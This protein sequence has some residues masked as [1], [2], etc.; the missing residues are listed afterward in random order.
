MNNLPIIFHETLTRQFGEIIREVEELIDK[1]RI[2]MTYENIYKVLADNSEKARNYSKVFTYD[3]YFQKNGEM[4]TLNKT[5]FIIQKELFIKT[6]EEVKTSEAII[7]TLDDDLD[8]SHQPYQDIYHFED[9]S[10]DEGLHLFKTPIAISNYCGIWHEFYNFKKAHKVTEDVCTSYF[11]L[12]ALCNVPEGVTNVKF[13]FNQETSGTRNSSLVKATPFELISLY[14][15]KNYI[16]NVISSINYNIDTDRDACSFLL[17]EI[18][19]ATRLYTMDDI[20]KHITTDIPVY[21]YTQGKT[22]VLGVYYYK[23][24][25]TDVCEY[26]FITEQDCFSVHMKIDYPFR[27]WYHTT[28]VLEFGSVATVFGCERT[29]TPEELV[30]LNGL[31]IGE[32]PIRYVANFDLDESSL[33]EFCNNEHH[34]HFNSE[35][36]NYFIQH[37]GAWIQS[38][39]ELHNAYK[40]SIEGLDR[41]RLYENGELCFTDEEKQAM[42]T[43]ELEQ[44]QL[45]STQQ[46][47]EQTIDEESDTVYDLADKDEFDFGSPKDDHG[48]DFGLNTDATDDEPEPCKRTNR[49]FIA[50]TL[51]IPIIMLASFI[52]LVF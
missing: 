42:R 47:D 11:I 13:I 37:K 2:I 51:A 49:K 36:A 41:R 28:E 14:V 45:A 8:H 24:E 30:S 18:Y 15:A 43:T 6:D 48:N 7:S 21:P 35:I 16:Q 3:E 39:V 44:P 46:P 12:N 5:A 9:I 19:K 50:C 40:I 10:T 31:I 32:T 52:Y 34:Q 25:D 38:P 33:L 22:E 1:G 17:K 27:D 26:L 20:D 29:I 23:P 4:L